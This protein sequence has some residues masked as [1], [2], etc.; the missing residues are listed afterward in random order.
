MLTDWDTSLIARFPLGMVASLRE[1]G[2]PSVSPKGT[3]LVLDDATIAYGDIRSPQT[4]A[5]VTRDPRVEVFFVD[6]FLRKGLRVRGQ[7][8]V[9]NAHAP[10]FAQLH[11]RWAETWGDLA[12]RIRFL[13]C[14]DIEST[15]P[16]VTPP[17]DDGVTE[18]EMLALYKARYAEIYP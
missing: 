13:V 12:K 5:N 2:A 17:Y 11:P 16:V 8:R 3:F 18:E 10:D 14:I 7:A 6:P 15:S 4:R 1:D 9:L